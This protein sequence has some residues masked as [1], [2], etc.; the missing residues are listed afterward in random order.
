[1][2]IVTKLTAAALGC[3]GLAGFALWWFADHRRGISWA[4]FF[5]RGRFPD[6]PHLSPSA[7]DDWLRDP[8][9]PAPQLVDARSEEEFALSHLAGAR[10]MDSEST[11]AAALSALDPAR[12]IVIYC[13]AGYRGATL[14][15]RLR[16]AGRR[17][18]WN[19]AGGIFA[20]ANARLPVER[21]GQPTRHI[22]PYSRLFSRLLKPE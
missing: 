7:L 3:M 22:H 4:V 17:D 10:R 2:K 18:V 1:M 19:L 20:W 5:M 12:P 8:Q 11:A 6:V 13:A 15:R 16:T 21:D 9:R 14:A